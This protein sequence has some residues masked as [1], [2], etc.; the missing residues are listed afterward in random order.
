VYDSKKSGAR[1]ISHLRFSPDPIRS[2]YLISSAQFVACHNFGFL[3][4][5]NMLDALEPEGIFLLNSPYSAAEV[6]D[7]MPREVQQQ[8]ID[9]KAK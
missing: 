8:L 2:T 5:Y 3:E 1:T 4:R 6:W 7:H 9:K